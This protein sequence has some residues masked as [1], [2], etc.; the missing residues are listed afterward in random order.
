MEPC[1][2]VMMQTVLPSFGDLLAFDAAAR[3]GSFTRAARDLNVSQP[4]V[5]RRVAA[6]EADLGV[7]LF[8]RETKPLHLTPT[9][10]TLFDVLRSSLSRLETAIAEIRRVQEE[11]KLTIA[12]APGFLTYWLLPRLSALTAGFPDQELRLLTGDQRQDLPEADIHVRFGDGDWPG[13]TAVKILGEEVFAV[14]SPL[15]LSR[16][17][18]KPDL[19]RLTTLRLLQLSDRL[20]RNYDWQHWFRAV[21]IDIP[22]KLNAIV[23]DDYSLLVSAALAGEGIALCWSGLLDQHLKT[24]ALVRISDEAVTSDRGY[25]ATFPTGTTEDSVISRLAHWLAQSATSPEA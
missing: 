8:G 15:F 18:T 14:C 17:G 4:A 23:F 16:Q 6:L 12:A 19:S 10:Q 20:D 1:V 9:G 25:F 11:R 22:R 5:S 13:V 7:T 3:H 2:G 24:G 21:G